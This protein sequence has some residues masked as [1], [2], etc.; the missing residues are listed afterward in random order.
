[1]NIRASAD[2]K[3]GNIAAIEQAITKRA[4]AA[5]TQGTQVVETAAKTLVPRDTGELA[6]S[7]GSVV[8]LT[9]RTVVGTIYAAAKHAAFVEYGTGLIGQANP[10]GPLPQTGVPF[11]GRWIYDYKNQQ[12]QGM[13]AQPYMRPALDQ[14]GPAILGAFRDQ[15]FKV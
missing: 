14:S 3:P 6:G 11:T 15:G 2:F 5:V 7:I 10:H 13:P 4:I 1:V 12:W 8:T 9:G